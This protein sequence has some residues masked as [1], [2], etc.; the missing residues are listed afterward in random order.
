MLPALAQCKKQ[1]LDAIL[2]RTAN[3]LTA[4]VARFCAN[5]LDILFS[6]CK[7][8]ERKVQTGRLGGP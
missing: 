7:A 1:R 6:N 5:F 2:T 8:A 4:H 3:W